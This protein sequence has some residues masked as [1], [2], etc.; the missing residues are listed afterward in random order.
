MNKDFSVEYK[1]YMKDITPDLWER[2]ESGL[3]PQ[4]S[5]QSKEIKKPGVVRM[6]KYLPWAAAILPMLI[7]SFLY[8]GSARFFHGPQAKKEMALEQAERMETADGITSMQTESARLATEVQDWTVSVTVLSLTSVPELL[9]NVIQET[10]E[11]STKSVT[12]DVY[13]VSDTSGGEAFTIAVA[14]EKEIALTEGTTYTLR[15]SKAPVDA[16]YEYLLESVEETP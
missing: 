14:Q 11:Q 9:Q 7:L 10:E 15:L 13:L 16:G 1:Q 4:K 8:Y 2:I 12:V 5:Y 6:Y 3:K